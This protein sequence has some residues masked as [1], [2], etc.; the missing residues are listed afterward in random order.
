MKKIR[1]NFLS[2]NV[3]F[4][5]NVGIKS[6]AHHELIKALKKPFFQYF[7]TAKDSRDVRM[8]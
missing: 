4:E 8:F 2:K 7:L 6:Q 1:K 5:K 3:I